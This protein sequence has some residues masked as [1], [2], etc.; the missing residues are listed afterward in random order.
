MRIRKEIKP[1]LQFKLP[2]SGLLILRRRF[3]KLGF[4]VM[5][6]RLPLKDGRVEL[7][8]YLFFLKNGLF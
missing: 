3:G 8:D 5:H 2:I 6:H 7:S 1:F 4:Q